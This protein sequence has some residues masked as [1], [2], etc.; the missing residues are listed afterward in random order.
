MKRFQFTLIELL[1]VIAI[2]AIL[3]AM[4]MPALQQARERGLAISCASNLK[5]LGSAYNQYSDDNDDYCLGL[6]FTGSNSNF[7]QDVLSWHYLPGTNVF[8]CAKYQREKWTVIP[9]KAYL[10]NH[11]LRKASSLALNWTSFGHS[12]A[13]TSS[14][15]CQ[16]RIKRVNFLKYPETTK[17]I[18]IGDSTNKTCLP[19]ISSYDGIKYGRPIYPLQ[20]TGVSTV[21][22]SHSGAGNFLH[23]GG[24]V[25][26]IKGTDFQ[27]AKHEYFNPC[28]ATNVLD[29]L[30]SDTIN[31]GS[32]AD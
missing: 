15:L 30:S 21:N 32:Y 19:S 10:I 11:D 5:Q 6:S 17:L 23:L 31:Y 25:S 16:A 24:H 9:N 8:S 28:I 2:I 29:R 14:G 27:S 1:V 20:P 12:W 3:A 22:L 4:L 18:L 26:S 7:W 13:G